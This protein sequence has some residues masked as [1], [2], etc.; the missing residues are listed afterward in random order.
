MRLT[1]KIEYALA[2]LYFLAYVRPQTYVQVRTLADE[3]GVPKRFLEQIFL[4]LREQGLLKSRRGAQGGYSLAV[5][6]EKITVAAVFDILESHPPGPAPDLAE[7]G[8]DRFVWN[9]RSAIHGA[10]ESITLES[11]ADEDLLEYL[12]SGS[13]NSVIYY[14]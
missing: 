3:I 12:R 1:K 2:G 11:L 13:D 6:P 10:L 7:T 14:I 9:A 8:A 4:A 5:E